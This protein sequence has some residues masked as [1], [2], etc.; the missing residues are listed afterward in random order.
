MR[1]HIVT[2]Y[3]TWNYNELDL[4]I[5][6]PF[7]WRPSWSQGDFSKTHIICRLT[8]TWLLSNLVMFLSSPCTTCSPHDIITNN[9]HT[10]T[11]IFRF[12]FKFGRFFFVVAVVVV[13]VV[14]DAQNTSDKLA[15]QMRCYIVDGI[16][17]QK[18]TCN[19]QISIVRLVSKLF[20][21]L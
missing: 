14:V 18:I 5:Y 17:E 16:F 8:I 3:D 13:V 12:I 15:T 6:L 20:W 4:F 11:R 19:V 9:V 7:N 2:S 10:T 1:T 21:T